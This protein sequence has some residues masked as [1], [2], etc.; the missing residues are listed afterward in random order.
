MFWRGERISIAKSGAL[1]RYSSPAIRSFD[2]YENVRHIGAY[3][4]RR[5]EDASELWKNLTEAGSSKK[6][7]NHHPEKHLYLGMRSSGP[8]FLEHLPARVFQ[9]GFFVVREA[10]ELV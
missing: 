10:E 4:P 7:K 6:L 3:P 9:S 1:C 8:G 5:S 2:T